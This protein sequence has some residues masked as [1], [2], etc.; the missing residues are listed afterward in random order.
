MDKPT[1]DSY[2]RE[3]VI[4]LQV[5]HWDGQ[6][7]WNGIDGRTLHAFARRGLVWFESV[8]PWAK[9]KRYRGGLTEKGLAVLN[10]LED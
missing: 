4:A 3:N 8:D 1:I 9:S 7:E 5:F 6:S 2:T 10:E